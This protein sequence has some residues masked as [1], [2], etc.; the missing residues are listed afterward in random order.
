[1]S[2]TLGTLGKIFSRDI[3]E[4]FFPGKT[5]FEISCNLDEMSNSIFLEN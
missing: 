5:G 1:M 3:L 2:L 4:D